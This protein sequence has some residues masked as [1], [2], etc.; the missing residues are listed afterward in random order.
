MAESKLGG[1]AR[2][3]EELEGRMVRWAADNG[4]V[5]VS[6]PLRDAGRMRLFV[7]CRDSLKMNLE[8]QIGVWRRMVTGRASLPN[9][10]R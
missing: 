7:T 2:S 6:A 4:A 10:H 8:A 9:C 3:G 5:R 1:E